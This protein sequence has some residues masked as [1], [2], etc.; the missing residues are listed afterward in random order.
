VRIDLPAHRGPSA[1]DV[2]TRR[3][4]DRGEGQR[5]LIVE[6]DDAVRDLVGLMLRR[7]GYQTVSAPTP[8]EAL[9]LVRY[10]EEPIDALV[11]DMVMPGMTGIE[12]ARAVRE[13]DR[14]LP[15]LLMSG[16]TA[17]TLP[18]A[19]ALP[20]GMELIRKPFTTEALLHAV[21]SVLNPA[22]RG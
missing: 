14:T 16:Y 20:E 7:G 15:V 1:G 22:P 19:A 10:V 11:T 8:A 13:H 21:A 4:P 3:A 6:D 9:D 12:L 5:L 17:G 2:E 18:D